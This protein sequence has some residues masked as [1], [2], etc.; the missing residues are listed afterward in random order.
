MFIE[1]LVSLKLPILPNVIYRFNV[2]SIKIPMAFFAET[3]KKILKFIW[4]NKGSQL[5]KNN[6]EKKEQS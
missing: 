3:E 4:N 2:I 1:D 5:V 6:I